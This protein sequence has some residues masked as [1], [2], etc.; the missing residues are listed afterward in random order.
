MEARTMRKMI[1]PLAALGLLAGT[2]RGGD[3]PRKEEYL[4]KLDSMRLDVDFRKQ[5]LDDALDFLREFS[6]LNFHV[7]AEVR[8]ALSEDQLLVTLRVKDLKLKTILGHLLTPRRLTL[9]YRDGVLVVTTRDKTDLKVFPAIY[10]VRDLLIKIPD[11]PGPRVELVSNDP[12]SDIRTGAVFTLE[13]PKQRIEDDFL[14]EMV[15]AN[16]GGTSWEDNPNASLRLV[17]GMLI[18]SQSKRVHKE[19]GRF[20]YKLGSF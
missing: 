8:E 6:G 4:K 7:D 12:G 3:D 19:I 14:V 1:L 15:Q 2:A 11:F 9:I 16:T 20:L 18:V 5:P 10:D 17:N 13:P